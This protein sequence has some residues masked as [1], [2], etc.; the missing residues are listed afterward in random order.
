M[1]A[2]ICV[3]LK[4][5]KKFLLLTAVLTSMTMSAQTSNFEEI[6]TSNGSIG[7]KVIN[8]ASLVL[9]IGEQLIFVDPQ[10][11]VDRYVDLKKPTLVLI[12]DVHPDHYDQKALELL[13]DENTGFIA[14][15][16]VMEMMPE[17]WQ[18][19]TKAL[20]NNQVSNSDDIQI[21]AIP[22]YNF[23]LNPE[24]P[25]PKGRGNGYVLEYDDLRIYISGD[26]G[27][28]PEMLALRNIDIAFICMNLP[29]TMDIQAAASAVKKFQPKVVYPFHYRNA[30]KSLS[31][32]DKF[33][34]IIGNEHVECVLRDWYAN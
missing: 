20:R 12:T 7:L 27:P 28:I 21:T 17:N 13:V 2:Y 18:S 33:C 15:P 23:P 31:D 14:P 6:K 16:A 10:G 25:H 22:M 29:Y 9:N 26:T 32:V 3:M 1:V 4:I 8:H 34:E 24:S 11:S 19:R 5:I 30:D